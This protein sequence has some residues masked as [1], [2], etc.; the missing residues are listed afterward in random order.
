MR[1][2]TR[3]TRI[4]AVL[5]AASSVTDMVRRFALGPGRDGGGDCAGEGLPD[6]RRTL[7][8]FA[9]IWQRENSLVWYEQFDHNQSVLILFFALS[10]NNVESF[11]HI[12]CFTWNVADDALRDDFKHPKYPDMI[13]PFTVLRRI[14]CV[15]APTKENVLKKYAEFKD[16]IQNLDGLLKH[17]S[18]YAFYNTSKYNFKRLLDDPENISKNLI[19][20]INGFSENVRDITEGRGRRAT[21]YLFPRLLAITEGGRL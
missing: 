14:D 9:L 8:A 5:P 10:D 19:D 4:K 11:Q 3:N 15:L 16:E 17:E 21:T 13:L 6:G 18:G 2:N 20:Y 1:A 7:N 12:T